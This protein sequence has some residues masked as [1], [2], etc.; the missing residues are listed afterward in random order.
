MNQDDHLSTTGHADFIFEVSP[1]PTVFDTVRRAIVDELE[2]DYTQV[3]GTDVREHIRVDVVDID[4]SSWVVEG[5]LNGGRAVSFEVTIRADNEATGDVLEFLRRRIDD[6]Y[7][8]HVDPDVVVFE[9]IGL[10]PR[11]WF[12]DA[13]VPPSIDGKPAT[14]DADG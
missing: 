6:R 2:A 8:P 11:A 7:G 14:N 3:L 5:Q 13:K 4:P 1:D 12:V 10:R 9:R